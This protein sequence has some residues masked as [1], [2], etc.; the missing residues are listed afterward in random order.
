M[1][2]TTALGYQR[3]SLPPGSEILF[4]SPTA[5][6][7]YRA[8]ILAVIAAILIQSALISWLLYEHWRRQRAEILARNTTVRVDPCES[9]GDGR[10]TIGLNSA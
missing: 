2:G 10:P 5:W 4:R 1:A 9:H 6:E 7:Q 8:Y 3:E